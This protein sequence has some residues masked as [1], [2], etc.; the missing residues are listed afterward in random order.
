VRSSRTAA[1]FEMATNAAA[2]GATDGATD[3]AAEPNALAVAASI[4]PQGRGH[5]TTRKPTWRHGSDFVE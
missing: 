5:R 3:G 2:D 1:L 4:K